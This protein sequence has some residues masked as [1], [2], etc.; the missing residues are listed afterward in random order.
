MTMK[1]FDQKLWQ[2]RAWKL[3]QQ[4]LSRVEGKKGKK[5]SI[6]DRMPAG[7]AWKR[8]TIAIKAMST[9][10]AWC[11]TRNVRVMFCD[12]PNGEYANNLI[13]ISIKARAAR[14]FNYLLHEI[15]HHLIDSSRANKIKKFPLGYA[16]SNDTRAC[17]TFGHRIDVVGEE[18]EAWYRG[19]RLAS[20]LK[21]SFDRK[22]FDDDRINA[23]RTYFKW[24]LRTHG[25]GK[26]SI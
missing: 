7:I 3:Y 9:V 25:Y 5:F 22:F 11:K 21:V 4:A 20:K 8:D 2:D 12:I 16:K 13:L 1:T 23:M 6:N 17:K 19:G 24:C 26:E 10:L 14:Q 18:L 15:G